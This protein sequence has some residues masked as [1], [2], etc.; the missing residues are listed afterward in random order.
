MVNSGQIAMREVQ[1]ISDTNG[2]PVGVIVPIEFWEEIESEKERGYLLKSVKMKERT[3]KSKD[4]RE[5]MSF[6]DL[7]EKLGI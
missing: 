2:T 4:R 6:E 3:L 1:Y 7:R 5:G